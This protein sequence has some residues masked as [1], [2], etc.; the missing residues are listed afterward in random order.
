[1]GRL[2]LV[3]AVLLAVG[4]GK[5][6]VQ[7]APIAWQEDGDA[8]EAMSRR[9]NKLLFVYVGAEMARSSRG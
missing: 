5:S 4:C 2:G 3:L 7:V 8:A 9:E 1:M 6:F